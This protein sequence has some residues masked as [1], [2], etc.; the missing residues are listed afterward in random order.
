M[1]SI[2]TAVRRLV[3][4]VLLVSAVGA[5]YAWWRDREQNSIAPAEWPPIT[6]PGSTPA[7]GPPSSSEIPVAASFVDPLVDAPGAR[8]ADGGAGRWVTPADDGSCPLDHPVKANDTSG[9]F[10]VPGGRFYERTKAVRCYPDDEAA[11]A[12]G[13][14]RAKN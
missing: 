3:L 8:S 6:S 4:A 9:I 2:V 7:P 5:V 12:D 10:H 14:R 1:T 13:Y 11:L